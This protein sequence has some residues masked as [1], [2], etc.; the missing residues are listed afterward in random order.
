[1]NIIGSRS[2]LI[3][4]SCA[5][6]LA[7]VVAIEG[8]YI[9]HER[10]GYFRPNDYVDAFI[11][12]LVMFVIRIGLF[13]WSFLLLYVSLAIQM[14]YQAQLIHFGNYPYALGSE[15]LG[16]MAMF[17][18]VSLSCLVIYVICGLVWLAGS[19]FVPKK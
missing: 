14:F 11:P 4:N 6:F 10:L 15:P 2:A 9:V 16:Y 12:A 5:L 3:A 18:F 8:A 17:L 7:S 1:M 13:S 19:A